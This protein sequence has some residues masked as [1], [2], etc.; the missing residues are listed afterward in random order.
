M[1]KTSTQ[2]NSMSGDLPVIRWMLILRPAIVTATL[3]AA[4]LILPR[5]SIDK[6]PIAVVLFGTYL[7]TLLYWLTLR[8]SGITQ[9]LVASQIA[10]DIFTITVIIHYTGGYDSSFVGFYF[11]SVMCASLFF[12]RVVTFMFSLFSVLFYLCYLF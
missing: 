12:R 6:F 11:L 8:I 9:P 2:K 5:G 3:G 4:M 1:P 10:F 7:L